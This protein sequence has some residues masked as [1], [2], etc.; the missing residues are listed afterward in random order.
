MRI[1]SC[2]QRLG[3]IGRLEISIL[4]I[5]FTK[6][7][8]MNKFHE[9][10]YF[11]AYV[12]AVKILVALVLLAPIIF[13]I[14]MFGL[15][16]SNNHSRWSEMGSAMS[17]LYTPILALLTLS[18][19]VIQVRM[20]TE[21]NKLAFDQQYITEARDDIQYYLFQL[22]NEVLKLIQMQLYCMNSPLCLS[23]RQ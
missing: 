21:M 13:Y 6:L 4:N 23:M 16:I 20:Q 22:S 11:K 17:G 9:L 10:K 3:C 5:T 1:Y 18:V 12:Q 14:H 7:L 19:L 8:F 15:S 2:C